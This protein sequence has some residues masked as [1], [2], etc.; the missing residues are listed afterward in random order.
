MQ[1]TCLLILLSNIQ[2]F[3]YEEVIEEVVYPDDVVIDETEVGALRPRRGGDRV[4][5]RQ[6]AGYRE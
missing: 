1:E 2:H 3:F 5:Y 6:L 4:N